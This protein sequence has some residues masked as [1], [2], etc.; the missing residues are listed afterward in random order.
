MA[1]ARDNAEAA[2]RLASSA[3]HSAANDYDNQMAAAIEK[4]SEAVSQIALTLHHMN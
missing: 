1:N 3:K 2:R 4:L